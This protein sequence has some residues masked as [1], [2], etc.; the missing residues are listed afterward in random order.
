MHYGCLFHDL[1]IAVKIA[2]GLTLVKHVRSKSANLNEKCVF[3]AYLGD[4]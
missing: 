2:F 1:I 3:F 4:L